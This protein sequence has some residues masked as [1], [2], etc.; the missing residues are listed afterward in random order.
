MNIP[1]SVILHIYY[2]FAL[3]WSRGTEKDTAGWSWGLV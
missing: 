1:L 2:A 3:G